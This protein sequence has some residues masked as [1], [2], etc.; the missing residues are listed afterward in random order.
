M[1]SELGDSPL[2]RVLAL[3]EPYNKK[4]IALTDGTKLNADL[5]IDS[6]SAMDLIM[7]IE[8]SFE[9]DIP[10]NLVSDIE[11]VGDLVSVVSQRMEQSS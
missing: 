7:E 4:G 3:L 9:I 2:E 1:A 10:I 6:V 11:T 5:E 8:D